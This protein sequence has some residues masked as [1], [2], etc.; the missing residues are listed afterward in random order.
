M[1]VFALLRSLLAINNL[2]YVPAFSVDREYAQK[3]KI[4]VYCFAK[5]LRMRRRSGG[6]Y[7]VRKHQ[8]I[9]FSSPFAIDRLI[10]VHATWV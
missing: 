5:F 1:L 4:P 3:T 10:Y 9:L 7:H 6:Y 2:I 8:L